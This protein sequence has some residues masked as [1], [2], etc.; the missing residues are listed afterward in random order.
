MSHTVHRVCTLCE[1]N[2]GLSFEVEN[3]RI[4]QVRPDEED[5]FS[6]GFAC[7]KGIAISKVHDDPDRLRTPVKR[8]ARGEF[9]P[10]G[11]D[12]ALALAASGLARVRAQHGGHAVA[13]YWGNP[14]IHNHGALL[15]RSS[16][17]KALGT[18]NNFGA[19]SQDTSPRFATSWYLYGSSLIVP[20]PDLDRTQY[21]LCIGANPVVSNGSAMTAPNVRQR[22]RRIRERGGRIVVIDPRRTE[23]A[24]EADEHVPVRPGSDAGLLLAMSAILV[25][26]GLAPIER[27]R[28]Q[29]TG[30]DEVE[31][32]LR[33]L[34]VDACAA[35]SGVPVETVARLARELA[36]SPAGVA[37]SRIGVCN[38]HF[39]TLGTYAT[40]LL[41]VV[42]GKL[43]EIGGAMFPTPAID[44]T[45]VTAML[46]DGHARFRS[47]VRGLPETVAELPSAVFADEIETPGE[48]QVKGLLTFAGN[49]VLSVPNGKRLD[50]ALD[51]LEF[52]VSIDLYVNETTR[53]ANVILP[54]S[55]TLA[56]EHFDVLF[57]LFAVRNVVRRSPPVVA[58][59]PDE[60]HDW[61]ILLALA[62]GLGGG[63]TGVKPLDTALNLA[64]RMGWTRWTPNPTL[65]FLLRTGAHGDGY[66]PWRKG[67]TMRDLENAPRGIDLGPLEPGVARRVK[68]RG[69]RVALAPPPILAEWD[70]LEN[71]LALPRPADQL[72]LIG[73]REQ[74]TNNSWM[75]N[76]PA[77]V[78]GQERCLLLMNPADAAARG[79]A[80]GERVVLSS[81]VHRGEV[82]LRVSD[83]MAPGVVSLPHGWGHAPAARWQRVA[84][85]TPG[86]SANDW[87]DESVVEGVVGQSVLNGVPVQ[88]LPREVRDER[89]RAAS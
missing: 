36:A 56:E 72:L 70:A 2:C 4:L 59:G 41:N 76:V 88:V 85:Q 37:Y 17:I 20:V 45:R 22:L 50:R 1:A 79:V 87:T 28:A 54:P 73:R 29:V 10:I 69:G 67:I 6:Q 89:I 66:L 7:P 55:W 74:R 80:D 40:D 39:G 26:E 12:E 68:H 27:I 11:W 8:S 47:R 38:G 52:M 18:R 57:P 75:H 86:V 33:A 14:I 71:A 19:S 77:M 64:E 60:R 49:P 30:W 44:V 15:L 34:D 65:S 35:A 81:R 46:G 24:R 58:H 78:S 32:R 21:L 43:G 82:R 23:T 61:E 25:R 83:E 16:V 13:A 62:R 63:P 53:H 84:G 51:T 5:P 31:R 9:E 48:G 42:A 3:D